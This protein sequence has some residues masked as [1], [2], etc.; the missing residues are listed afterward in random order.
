MYLQF[1]SLSDCE[2][3]SQKSP[4]T[5]RKCSI[6]TYTTQINSNNRLHE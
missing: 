4:E 1:Y 6:N 3:L 5:K 2:N